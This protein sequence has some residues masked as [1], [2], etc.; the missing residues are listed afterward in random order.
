MQPKN[1]FA[2]SC[3][4]LLNIGSFGHQTDTVLDLV[5]VRFR[6]GSCDN[7]AIKVLLLENV[8]ESLMTGF[9]CL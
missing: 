5:L 2:V 1:G 3:S 8:H 6:Q 9:Y 4:S 7:S